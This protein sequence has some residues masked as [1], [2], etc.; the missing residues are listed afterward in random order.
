MKRLLL[1]T[2]FLT[3]VPIKK[4]PESS[5]QDLAGSM[6]YFPLVG[7]FQGFVLTA[8]YYGL[9]RVLPNGAALVI[10]LCIHI[11]ING[12]LHIDGFA[13]TVDAVAGGNTRE[14]R[15]RIM[16]DSSVGAI[17]VSFTVLLLLLKFVAVSEMPGFN[18]RMRSVLFLPV[19]GR[20]AMVFLSCILP[21]A[22]DGEGIGRA[23]SRN[24][25]KVLLL[26][27]A[28]TIGLSYALFRLRGVFI[29][30]GIALLVWLSALFFRKRLG[31]VTGDVFGFTNEASE[32]LSL[33]LVLALIGIRL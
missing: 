4:W 16:R 10:V 19:I 3:I 12:G 22:R 27:S 5:A 21:Y 32:A 30:A 9:N 33:L 20:W 29:I 28:V 25:P 26:A 24:S 31:G 11:L 1:A 14:E 6:A 7:A 8:V 15:L 17:G 23:F 13:D 2:G 18:W